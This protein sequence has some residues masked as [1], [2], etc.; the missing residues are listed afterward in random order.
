MRAMKE[1]IQQIHELLLENEVDQALEKLRRVLAISNSELVNDA[2][3]LS[4]QHSKLKSDVRKGIIDYAQENLRH[5][6]IMHAILCLVDE[7]RKT[8]EILTVFEAA[9]SE[10]DQSVQAKQQAPLP[11][12]IKDGLYDRM[13]NF[14][15]KNAQAALLWI[16]DTPANISHECELLRTIGL[17][18]DVASSSEEGLQMLQNRHYHLLLSDVSRAARKDEG[19]QFH[20]QL[21][22]A[23]TDLPTIFYV[24]NADRSL[25]VPPFAFGITDR[26]DMLF[27]LVFD[28]LARL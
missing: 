25:G 4:G 21:L 2:L 26:P 8:P 22:Q 1:V 27:H 19:I 20:Q 12:W 9:A 5:N 18:V 3:L 14:K 13:A 7:L 28:V 23:G 6:Q 24:G 16:D 10:I 15:L 17:S 11:N